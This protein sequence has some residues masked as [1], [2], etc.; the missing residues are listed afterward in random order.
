M[1][2]RRTVALCV[3]LL[4]P[5]AAVSAQALP[6]GIDV[7]RVTTEPA[8]ARRAPRILCVVAHPDDEIAFAGTLYKT[9]THLGG[10]CDVLVITNGEA[11]YKYSLL[12]ER[13]YGLELT[14][15]EVGR[16]EL[17][18]IRQREMTEAARVLGVRDLLFLHQT[19]HRYT[20]DPNEVL[21]EDAG[22][23]DLA[24][25]RHALDRV[26]EV[27]GYDF[28]FVHLPTPTTHGHHQAASILALE[29]IARR[30]PGRRPVALA[31]F[32]AGREVRRPEVPDMLPGWPV[33]RHL[34][35]AGPFVFD[36]S[37]K[38]GFRDRLDYRVITNLAMAQHR[39]QG[40][41][42]LM[43]G[44]ST[45]EAFVIF[46]L[47]TPDAVARA[48]ELF[49]R[50]GEPQFGPMDYDEDGNLLQRR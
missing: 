34:R 35:D 47:Q 29:A 42:L 10:A 16:R 25:V 30:A 11:G 5:T 22:V 38:F 44:R 31:S 40:T 43:A 6:D 17:P 13:I 36:R 18:A 15:P 41:Y 4:S 46:A 48:Q 7:V 32:P 1:K 37:Q 28:V 24:F 26:L 19:D 12:A 49:A 8:P 45:A 21:A 33:T 23:W 9:S 14:D 39:S 50:L 20:Q 2:A 27:R 3:A